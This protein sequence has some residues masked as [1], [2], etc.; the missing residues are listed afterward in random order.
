MR[1]HNDIAN[2]TT[3]ADNMTK[4][5]AL[6]KAAAARHAAKVALER[7]ALYATSFGSAT[8]ISQQAMLDHDV[9]LEVFNKWMDIADLHQSKRA[10]LVRK[11]LIPTYMFAY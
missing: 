2:D 5:E 11:N 1:C 10:A 8:E 3:G 7:H 6:A 4:N 9:A